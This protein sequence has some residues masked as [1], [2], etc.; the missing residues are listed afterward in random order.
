MIEKQKELLEKFT[1][2]NKT[3]SLNIEEELLIAYWKLIPIYFPMELNK[4]E[5]IS[6]DYGLRKH[7]IYKKWEFHRGIDFVAK[8]GTN[9]ISTC[10]GVV[11]TARKSRFGYGNLVIIYSGSYKTLYAHLDKINVKVGQKVKLGNKIGTLGSSG[12]STGPHLHYEILNNNIPTDPMFFT[13]NERTSRSYK[14]YISK[15]IALEKI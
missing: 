9:I 2:I 7:P 11:T 8:K 12:L 5:Y 14:N 13:Y 15:S 10:D 3:I 6:S 4:L 1:K